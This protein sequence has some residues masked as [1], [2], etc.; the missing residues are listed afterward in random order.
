[1]VISSRVGCGTGVLSQYL[2]N[3][4]SWNVTGIDL[5]ASQIEEAKINDGFG[6]NRVAFHEADAT[7]LPFLEI[8]PIPRDWLHF[9]INFLKVDFL[10]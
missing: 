10:K 6:K 3:E 7:Q 5:D 8:Y 4:Y 9:S 2:A 1:M